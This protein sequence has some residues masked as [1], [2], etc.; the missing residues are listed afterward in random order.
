MYINYIMATNQIVNNLTQLE[1]NVLKISNNIKKIQNENVRELVDDLLSKIESFNLN[2]NKKAGL[3]NIVIEK[4]FG[5]LEYK[6]D[7]DAIAK[8]L[9]SIPTNNLF[10]YKLNANF[11]AINSFNNKIV[12]SNKKHFWKRYITDSIVLLTNLNR[13]KRNNV[14]TPNLKKNLPSM[15]A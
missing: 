4:L 1:K 13:S 8:E 7:L 6:N 11:E 14:Y 5:T 9:K 2:N 12:N 10:K 15:S 3:K